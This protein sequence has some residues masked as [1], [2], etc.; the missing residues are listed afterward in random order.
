MLKREESRPESRIELASVDPPGQPSDTFL[1]DLEA[2]TACRGWLASP[3]AEPA[4]TAATIASC[5]RHRGG[6]AVNVP[7]C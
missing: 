5:G 2:P 1:W 7:Q 4:A 6:L 3:G